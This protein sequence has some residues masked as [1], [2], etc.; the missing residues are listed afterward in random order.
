M[1]NADEYFRAQVP[2]QQVRNADEYSRIQAS[3]MMNTGPPKDSIPML[4]EELP[5]E[6]IMNADEHSRIRAQQRKK[7]T[8]ITEKP[9]IFSFQQTEDEK[10]NHI[11]RNDDKEKTKSDSGDKENVNDDKK[12]TRSDS[13]DKENVNEVQAPTTSSSSSSSFLEGRSLDNIQE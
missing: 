2:H 9:Y 4:N 10:T 7:D 12:K 6:P 11:K 8:L 3:K 1:R 5:H 13:E